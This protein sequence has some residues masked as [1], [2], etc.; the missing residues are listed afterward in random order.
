MRIRTFKSDVLGIYRSCIGRKTGW[1]VAGMAWMAA[2]TLQ[3]QTTPEYVQKDIIVTASRVPVVASDLTR[4]VTVLT[5]EDIRRAPVNSVQELLQYAGGVDVRQRG[6]A[7]TQADVSVRGGSFEQTLILLDGVRVSDPQT[8]HHSMNLPV[9]LVDIERIEILKGQGSHIYGPNAFSGVVNIITKKTSGSR[10]EAQV[11]GGEHGYYNGALSLA[12]PI[13]PVG[14]KVSGARQKADGDR[15][16]TQFTNDNASAAVSLA[17]DSTTA[18]LFF[19][20]DNKEF[21]ANGFYSTR[22]PDQW[23]HTTTRLATA[24]V[25]VSQGALL[26]SSQVSWRRNDDEYRLKYREPSF[27]QNI[28]RTNVYNVDVQASL[29]TGLGTTV[30]G[31]QYMQDDISSTNLGDHARYNKGIFAEQ[32]F[33]PVHNFLVTLGGFAYDYATIGWKVWPGLEAAWKAADNVRV[34]GSVGKA[35]RMPSYTDLYYQDPVT[36]GNPNLTY[37]ETV[38]YEVGVVY[39]QPAWRAEATVFAKQGRNIIDWVRT[40]DVEL[41]AV[42]NIASVNTTGVEVNTALYPNRLLE[43]FPVQAVTLAYTWLNSDKQTDGLSSRYVLDY[44]QHQFVVGI[45]NELPFDIQQRWA[46]RYVSR[47]S[48]DNYALVDT[49][50]ARKFSDVNVFLRAVNLFNTT[51]EEIPGATLPGRWIYAGVQVNM[52]GW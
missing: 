47:R 21:G 4:S 14:I 2:L 39:E 40:T 50:I 30:L 41:W 46:V 36:Q 16:N 37:E 35:F 12:Y 28:H 15:Y 13:G 7:G 42:R 20:Y 9:A 25:Q 51:Y 48:L 44:L 45:N 52:Q 18:H 17:V 38:N 33:A 32:T 43:N 49:Q 23:E 24:D 6:I 34:F 27:Y 31:G 10:A 3:G 26:L 11:T 8:A 22:F 29:V 19:G 5:A 1:T